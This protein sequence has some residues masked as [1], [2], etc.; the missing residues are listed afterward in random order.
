MAYLTFRDLLRQVAS[1]DME[2]DPI[3]ETKQI[4]LTK[5]SHSLNGKALDTIPEFNFYRKPPP[6]VAFSHKL[7][8]GSQCCRQNGNFVIGAMVK[9]T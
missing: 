7:L 3:E 8:M 4:D 1:E 2:S 6:V 5:E 9:S